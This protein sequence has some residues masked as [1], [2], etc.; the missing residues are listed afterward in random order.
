MNALISMALPPEAHRI[1]LETGAGAGPM[2]ASAAQWSSLSSEYASAAAELAASVGGMQWQ[3]AGS[4][5]YEA[6]H[7]P[8]V[9]WMAKTSADYAQLAAAQEEAAAAHTAALVTTPT[10]P[11]LAANHAVHGV[12]AATNFLGINTI[13]LALNEADYARMWVQAATAMDVYSATS[14][15]AVI[16][17]PEPTLAPLLVAPGVEAAP[18]AVAVLSGLLGVIITTIIQLINGEITL[19][20]AIQI[21]LYAIYVNVIVLLLSLI[22]F[23]IANPWVVAVGFLLLPAL[24]SGPVLAV[25]AP[26]AAPIAVPLGVGRHLYDLQTVDAGLAGHQ[27]AGALSP[28]IITRPSGL[29]TLAGREFEGGPRSP[30]LPT[31][32]GV[33]G[34]AT[35]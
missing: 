8:Y 26:V 19:I 25:G 1:L 4:E 33:Q 34:S 32:W 30:M 7:L 3:G 31:G 24:A 5:S 6:A 2:F 35:L 27:G 18:A 15:A 10:L 28:G 21:I 29:I 12:L 9:A 17:A 13:P 20:L 22:G 11:E 14:N 23:I 16:A